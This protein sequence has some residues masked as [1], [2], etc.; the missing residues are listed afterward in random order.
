MSIQ[1]TTLNVNGMGDNSKRNAIFNWC[2]KQKFD[3]ICLQE[4]HC[5]N[6]IE[7]K[8]RKEWGGNSFWNNGTKAQKGVAVLFK[9][10]FK[11]NVNV[12]NTDQNGRH[13]Q[14]EFKID[15]DEIF[16]ITNVY[17][18]N[19]PSDRKR[20]LEELNIDNDENILNLVVGDFNC[21]LNKNLDRKPIPL[22]DDIGKN[23]F[24]NFIQ[25]F[26]LNDIYRK[27][28]PKTKRYTFKR[29]NS[30]SRIDYIL[31]NNNTDHR[32]YNPKIRYFPFSD[33]DG[34]TITLKI[35]QVERGPGCWKM[36]N[37]VITTS[38]FKNTFEIFWGKWKTNIHNVNM[39]KNKLQF[40]DLTKVKIKDITIEIAKKLKTDESELKCWE[41]DLEN[42][43]L[44]RTL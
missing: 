18:P 32:L 31:T 34:V 14:C 9:E 5:I 23:E 27:R 26:D 43:L 12:N 44:K 37:N 19:I 25:K 35:K 7:S 22:R 40:W 36:N 15:T 38:L 33:H 4:T 3:V 28:N 11:Y 39:F 30:H 21:T 10:G 8:W 24:E 29:V 1:I 13:I 20:F 16:R 41:K 6:T 2:R 17:V 42:L